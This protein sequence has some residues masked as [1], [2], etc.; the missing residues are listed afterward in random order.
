MPGNKLTFSNL[1][2]H[3]KALDSVIGLSK[4]EGSWNDYGLLSKLQ[5]LKHRVLSSATLAVNVWHSKEGTRMVPCCAHYTV[6]ILTT[7]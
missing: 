2:S 5:V 4:C 3:T 6:N 1:I 7:L